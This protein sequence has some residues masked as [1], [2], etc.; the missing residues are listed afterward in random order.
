MR[1]PRLPALCLI[2]FILSC[3]ETSVVVAQPAVVQ[4][5][6]SALEIKVDQFDHFMKDGLQV[7]LCQPEIRDLLTKIRSECP[8]EG[9][10]AAVEA[11]AEGAEAEK[12]ATGSE[13]RQSCPTPKLKGAFFQLKRQFNNT[14]VG[15][16]LLNYIRHAIVYMTPESDQIADARE[17]K[18]KELAE[19]YRLPRTRYAVLVSPAKSGAPDADR[20]GKV[21]IEHL[22]KHG[23]PASLIDGPWIYNLGLKQGDLK[24][25]TDQPVENEGR[26]LDRAVVIL[27]T[28]C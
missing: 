19:E 13:S 14:P 17:K 6:R 26:D 8:A 28:D 22:L 5:Q 20:R 11:A 15:P 23:V 21:I 10:A 4:P 25:M 24:R 12:G 9:G 18:I 2:P 16:T 27:R 7:L 1:L 3:A